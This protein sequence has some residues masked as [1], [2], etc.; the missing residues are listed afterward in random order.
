MKIILVLLFF[1]VML[2]IS[3]ETPKK[4]VEGIV[5]Q[6][7][8]FL[9][10]NMG[11]ID[12][13]AYDSIFFLTRC[14]K[15]TPYIKNYLSD[16]LKTSDTVFQK[17]D[18]ENLSIE[19]YKIKANSNFHLNGVS[20]KDT[21]ISVS[22][23]NGFELYDSKIPFLLKIKDGKVATFGMMQ[24]SDQIYLIGFCE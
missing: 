4:Q 17:L 10:K 20:D 1:F 13:T 19:Y 12:R 15:D 11:R 22:D 2:F 14:E 16:I 6:K 5:Y 3:C 23:K 21:I 24:K 7:V 9:F 18:K 8:A